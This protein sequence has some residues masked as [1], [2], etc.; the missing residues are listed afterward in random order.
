MMLIQENRITLK[1]I[2]QIFPTAQKTE[3]IRKTYQYT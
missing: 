1:E 3:F 2:Q